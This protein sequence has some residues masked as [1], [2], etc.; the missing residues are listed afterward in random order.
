MDQKRIDIES[1][2]YRSEKLDG[3]YTEIRHLISGTGEDY[4][5]LLKTRTGKYSSISVSRMVDDLTGCLA[6]YRSYEAAVRKSHQAK[7][8]KMILSDED[9]KFYEAFFYLMLGLATYDNTGFYTRCCRP[10]TWDAL[11]DRINEPVEYASNAELDSDLILFDIQGLEPL[12]VPSGIFVDICNA[13][14]QVTGKDFSSLLSGKERKAAFKHMTKEEIR[15][16]EDPEKKLEDDISFLEKANLN[17]DKQ[18]LEA[19]FASVEKALREDPDIIEDPLSGEDPAGYHKTSADNWTEYFTDKNR[20]RE[21]CLTVKNGILE[22][23]KKGYAFRKEIGMA[24]KLYLFHNN[25]SKIT[26]DDSFF[27]VYIYLER[28]KKAA[29]NSISENRQ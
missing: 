5:H 7:M 21:S 29:E 12:R 14:V 16:A 23:V 19:E 10:G 25:I 27:T 20:F 15:Y 13:F 17:E 26:D 2:L 4:T 22:K 9:R 11:L 1:L 3:K 28:A 6:E 8:E 18:I 24:V